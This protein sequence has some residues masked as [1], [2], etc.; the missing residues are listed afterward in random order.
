MNHMPLTRICTM[1]GLSYS[2]VRNSLAYKLFSPLTT[3]DFKLLTPEEIR[4][5]YEK[6][7]FLKC[8]AP[9]GAWRPTVAKDKDLRAE[10]SRLKRIIQLRV[11]EKYT[12][13]SIMDEYEVSY[14]KGINAVTTSDLEFKTATEIMEEQKE[15][16]HIRMHQKYLEDQEKDVPVRLND[17]D[18]TLD[19]MYDEMKIA[20]FWIYVYVV[21]SFIVFVSSLLC[22]FL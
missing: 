13:E 21:V 10:C 12:P 9:A 4:A 14:D 17:I 19:R 8:A 6:I 2:M 1:Y 22:F 7:M 11:I 20:G 15:N 3:E 5:L 18:N 16:A